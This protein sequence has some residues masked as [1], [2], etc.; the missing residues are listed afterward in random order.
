MTSQYLNNH[1]LKPLLAH[2]NAR[3]LLTHWMKSKIR[4]VHSRRADG[5]NEASA[6]AFCF[7]VIGE[8]VIH[9]ASALKALPDEFI[10]GILLHEVVHMLIE[11]KGDPELGVDEWVLEHVPEAGYC[12]KTAKYED[13]DGA[14]RIAK[15]IECVSKKFLDLIGVSE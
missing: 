12:Y 15:N 6:R 9:Y 1:Y 7:V 2:L 13:F 3:G 8:F 5:N 10:V 11:E 4:T 14:R